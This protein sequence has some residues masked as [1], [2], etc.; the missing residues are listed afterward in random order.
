[1]RASN[2]VWLLRMMTRCGAVGPF[3]IRSQVKQI[4]LIK[5]AVF[6]T[7]DANDKRQQYLVCILAKQVADNTSSSPINVL[8]DR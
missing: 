1:M 7:C 3:A 5:M 6:I 8:P 4:K 2:S